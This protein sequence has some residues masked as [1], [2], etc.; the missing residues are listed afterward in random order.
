MA[1]SSSG[2]E[3]G[4]V[5]EVLWAAEDRAATGL[6]FLVPRNLAVTI[7]QIICKAMTEAAG[8]QRN[9]RVRSALISFTFTG[10][11]A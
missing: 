1:A 6:E 11:I 7:S 8:P 9:P 5:E 2:E 3:P 4:A 10:S